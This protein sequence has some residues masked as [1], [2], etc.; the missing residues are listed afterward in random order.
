MD[1]RENQR[2]SRSDK[3]SSREGGRGGYVIVIAS[4]AKQSSGSAASL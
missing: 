3:G 1:C 4:A 2:F